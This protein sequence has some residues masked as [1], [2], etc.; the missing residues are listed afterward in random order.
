MEIAREQQL[1]LTGVEQSLVLDVPHIVHRRRVASGTVLA[2]ERQ[3]AY[4]RAMS[5][6]MDRIKKLLGMGK[7]P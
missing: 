3:E 5:A 6:L 4:T 2:Y 7:K 1:V